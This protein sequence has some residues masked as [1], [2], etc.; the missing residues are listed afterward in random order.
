[1]PKKLTMLGALTAALVFGYFGLFNSTSSGAPLLQFATSGAAEISVDQC[2]DTNPANYPTISG[3]RVVCNPANPA[4]LPVNTGVTTWTV[5]NLP[6]GN[7]L[8]LPATFT[9]SDTG[10]WQNAAV[11]CTPGANNR[12]TAG[13]TTGN[14][15]SRTDIGCQQLIDI[16]A[17]G[18]PGGDPATW[19]DSTKWTPPTFT[20]IAASVAQGGNGQL[21]SA[22]PDS[23]IHS[24]VPFPSTW[25]FRSSDLSLLT[26]LYIG[27]TIGF[28]IPGGSKLNLVAYNSTYPGQTGLVASVALLGGSPD[29]PPSDD[30][31]LCLSAP[32]DSISETNYLVT[33]AA[34][35]RVPRWTILQSD[36]DPTDR[37]VTR[38]LDWQCDVVGAPGTTDAD[39][40]CDVTPSDT[41]DGNK[42]IDGD[43][44]PDGIERALGSS[45]TAADTDG[46]GSNDF[47]EMFQFTDPT[48]TDS[49]NDGQADRQDLIPTNGANVPAGNNL[50]VAAL[51]PELLYDSADLTDDNCPNEPNASQLNTDSLWQF[52][53]MGGNADP[54]GAGPLLGQ[55]T[56]TGDRTNP[57]EDAQGDACDTDD[58]NDALP[59]ATEPLLRIIPWS[60][61]TDPGG[62]CD[63]APSCS[64]SGDVADTSVCVGV[65]TY[66]AASAPIRTMSP[67]QGDV[68]FDLVLDGR[69]CQFRSRPDA[70]CRAAAADAGCVSLPEAQNCGSGAIVPTAAGCA[71]PAGNAAIPGGGDT[72]ADGLY[73]PGTAAGHGATE[74]FFRTQQWNTAPA[75]QNDDLDADGLAGAAD[76]DSDRDTVGTS[77]T[78]AGIRDGW[79][80]RNYG[81]EPFAPDTDGD[82]CQDGDEIA[83]INGDGAQNPGDSGLRAQA[84]GGHD[85]APANGRMDTNVTNVQGVSR[86]SLAT[87]RDFNKDGSN[88]PADSGILAA[89][90]AAAGACSPYTETGITPTNVAKGL[91]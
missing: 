91:P 59:D 81:T 41:N 50:S 61:F 60:G 14:I 27:G 70:S 12:C 58:D 64:T 26:L 65:A 35:T 15:T 8:T 72:D 19:P 1:M 71:Q 9:P 78:F 5:I 47:T 13:T 39:S 54:D 57:D 2:Y 20:R 37:S 43:L 7:R 46:D 86:Y 85:S 62:A 82:G 90:I 55:N 48:D 74:T 16:L 28:P 75:V 51:N 67:L 44:V 17:S 30:T 38:L 87:N 21:G 45:P 42:D 79:E 29:N 76:P 23:Y 69:E 31:T 56:S 4:V 40:D 80:L 77:G 63:P 66:P 52:H 83:D 34:A 73:M 33:P 49:D 10:E 36:Q 53:G 84:T 3:G 6:V 24:A 88:N 11:G 18:G 22:D 89:A 32:Q 25:D 68:D